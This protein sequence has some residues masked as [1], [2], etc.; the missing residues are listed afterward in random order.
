MLRP[1]YDRVMFSPPPPTHPQLY[2]LPNC[3]LFHTRIVHGT[4]APVYN[5]VFPDRDQSK[6]QQA[7]DS[8]L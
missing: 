2:L 5:N 3:L 7:S 1:R 4:E 8:Q 6:Q